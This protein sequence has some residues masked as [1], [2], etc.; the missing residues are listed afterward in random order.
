MSTAES[1]CTVCG[2]GGSKWIISRVI[3]GK[4]FTV[5]QCKVCDHG[6]MHP[7]PTIDLTS[8]LAKDYGLGVD[9]TIENKEAMNHFDHLFETWINNHFS[10]QDRSLLNVANEEG[11][12][13]NVARRYGWSTTTFIFKDLMSLLSELAETGSDVKE[14]LPDFYG[15][16]SLVVLNH[17]FEHF[18]D[19]VKAIMTVAPWLK[20]N[21]CILVVVPN[22]DSDEA[23]MDGHKWKYINIPFHINYF[24]KLSLDSLFTRKLAEHGLKFTK[25]FQSTFPPPGHKEGESITTM[26]RLE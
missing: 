18:F 25:V 3:D 13:E 24:N 15:K 1:N 19:P 8:S 10:T 12:F 17:V 16:F 7:L 23:R 9:N 21:G 6:Y 5:R 4:L 11:A 26:Y 22:I 2:Y 20:H 14:L